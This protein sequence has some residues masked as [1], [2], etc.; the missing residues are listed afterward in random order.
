MGDKAMTDYVSAILENRYAR[1]A[2]PA[3]ISVIDNAEKGIKYALKH[4][5][6]KALNKSAYDKNEYDENEDYFGVTFLNDINVANAAET[7]R[8]AMRKQITL[9]VKQSGD[10]VLCKCCGGLIGDLNSSMQPNYCPNCGQRLGWAVL[11]RMRAVKSEEDT[12]F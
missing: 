7:A 12:Q 1:E 4:N 10:T 6:F 5:S 3:E 2:T 9:A 11:N 8:Q